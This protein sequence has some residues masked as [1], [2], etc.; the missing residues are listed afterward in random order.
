MLRLEEIGA[1]ASKEY[2]L[3]KAM[4]KMRTEWEETEFT[5]I[6][7]RDTVS[8]LC[9]RSALP[10]YSPFNPQ[11]GKGVCVC[12]CVCGGGG[13]LCRPY[14][15]NNVEVSGTMFCTSTKSRVAQSD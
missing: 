11:R 7:Y 10:T 3:E 6:D 13:C 12:V 5:F 15:N 9:E 1:A 14:S 8:L 4:E 2:S